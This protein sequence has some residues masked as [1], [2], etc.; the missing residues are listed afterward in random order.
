MN[1][2]HLIIIAIV[3]ILVLQAVVLY[4]LGHPLICDCGYV[5]IWDNV[6][7]GSE[8]SQHIFDWYTLSHI[9]HGFIVYFLLWLAGL[10]KRGWSIGA[11]FLMALL[12]SAGWEMFENTQFVVARYQEAT[13]SSNYYGDSIIN[14][15]MDSVSMLF[16]FWLAWRLPVDMVIILAILMELT[17]A[18]VIHDNLILNIIMLAYPFQSILQWQTG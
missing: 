7:E 11:L 4:D 9:I 12:I 16:G 17:A 14:S 6:I 1:K 18:A 15:L 5:K 8:N 3:I 13:I 2:N 10:R